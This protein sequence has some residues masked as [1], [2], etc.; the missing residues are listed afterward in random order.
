MYIKYPRTYK[1]LK[2]LGFSPMK[3]NEVLLDAH[4]GVGAAMMFIR[5]AFAT[6][7]A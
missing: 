7:R 1:Q 6:R 3:A 4:R 5:I 2:R